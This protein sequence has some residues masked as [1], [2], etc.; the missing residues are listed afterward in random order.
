MLAQKSF[1]NIFM[2][3]L[4]CIQLAQLGRARCPPHNHVEK[5]LVQIK[6]AAAY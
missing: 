2:N 3:K 6:G 5:I 4:L 1:K